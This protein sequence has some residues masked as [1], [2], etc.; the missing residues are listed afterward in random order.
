MFMM[1]W[2]LRESDVV[3]FDGDDYSDDA[4]G[5]AIAIALRS[6]SCANECHAAAAVVEMTSRSFSSR[7]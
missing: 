3:V 1:L 6:P 5:R 4:Y 2:A 7:H